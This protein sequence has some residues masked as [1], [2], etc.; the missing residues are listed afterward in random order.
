MSLKRFFDSLFIISNNLQARLQHDEL[1][2]IDSLH[3]LVMFHFSYTYNI[4]SWKLWQ[5]QVRGAFNKF[6]DFFIQA[7]KIVID[8]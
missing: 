1:S 4:F 3:F 8:S 6:G 2:I 5:I 7:F